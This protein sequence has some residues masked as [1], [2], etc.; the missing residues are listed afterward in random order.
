MFLMSE[1]F[2]KEEHFGGE[3]PMLSQTPADLEPTRGNHDNIHTSKKWTVQ[4]LLMI[5]SHMRKHYL[6]PIPLSFFYF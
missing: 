1:K 5:S 3:C 4:K 6:P 2:R